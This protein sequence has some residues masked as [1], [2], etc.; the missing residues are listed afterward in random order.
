MK[1]KLTKISGTMD[2]MRS[3]MRSKC[4]EEGDQSIENGF[5]SKK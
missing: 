2:S 1:L 3:S 4:V 5:T